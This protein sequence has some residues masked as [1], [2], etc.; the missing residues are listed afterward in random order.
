MK[1]KKTTKNETSKK[2]KDKD[3]GKDFLE[4]LIKLYEIQENI[5]I[6]YKVKEI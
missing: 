6:T 5:K 1:N 3:K 4:F 2:I